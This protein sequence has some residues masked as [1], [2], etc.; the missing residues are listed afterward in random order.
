[1]IDTIKKDWSAKIL[2]V[3]MGALTLWWVVLRFMGL[4]NDSTQNQFFAAV[5]GLLGLM[6]GLWGLQ[7]AKK[8]GGLSSVMGKSLLFF[9]IGLLFQ[10][11]GQI[12]YS[13]YIYLLKIA[14]P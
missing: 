10:E 12:I 8:W 9:S 7:I 5:Y 14:V 1:M 6:G 2:L 11:I 13:S 3:I 4:P